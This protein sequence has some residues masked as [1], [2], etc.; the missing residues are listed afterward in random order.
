[1]AT[2]TRSAAVALFK[3]LGITSA[4]K[5]TKKRI[6]AKAAGVD[7]MVDDETFI[8]DKGGAEALVICLEAIKNDED[9]EVVADPKPAEKAPPAKKAAAKK[10][11]KAKAAPVKKDKKAKKDKP[12]KNTPPETTRIPGVRETRTRPY[13]A[14]TIIAEHGLEAGVTEAMVAELDD[15]YGKTNPAE[16]LFA[17]RNA[18][19]SIRGFGVEV[20][21]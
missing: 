13:L 11:A 16:S 5:W 9:I 2:I 6:E 3:G 21:A 18:W 7:E 1:M 20:N 17:L 12:A 10:P 8:E 4:G 19:H 15:L 14:G